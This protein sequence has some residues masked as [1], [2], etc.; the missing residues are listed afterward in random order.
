MERSLTAVTSSDPP[1]LN[2]LGQIRS[3]VQVIVGDLDDPEILRVAE[4]VAA[5]IQGTKIATI[6]GVAH[7]PNMEEPGRFNQIV[8]EFLSDLEKEVRVE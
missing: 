8:I 5:E 7:L 3:L 2:Q 6:E 1:A 4:F